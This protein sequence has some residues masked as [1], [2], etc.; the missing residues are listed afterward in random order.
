MTERQ[1]EADRW[2]AEVTEA[3]CRN[4]ARLLNVLKGDIPA[5]LR[6]TL[7][8]ADVFQELAVR[9]YNTPP[10]SV[11]NWDHWLFRAARSVLLNQ[12]RDWT[13]LK[14]G[15]GFSHV[16]H[17]GTSCIEL[18]EE[19]QLD[20]QTPSRVLKDHEVADAVSM[21]IASLPDELRTVLS[22]SRFEGLSYREIAERTGQTEANVARL[23]VRGLN[24]LRMR[25]KD[26]ALSL[27]S[28]HTLE[29]QDPDADTDNDGRATRGPDASSS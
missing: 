29:V 6:S 28:V 25:L 27:S 3:L 10:D 20:T 18:L 17:H 8:V 26:V 1:A 16:E 13:R 7:A 11:R 12:V 14:R 2:R 9:A 15:G 21:A 4:R 5:R 19:L 22:L 23:A 24:E